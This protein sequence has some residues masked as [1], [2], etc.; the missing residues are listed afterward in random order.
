LRKDKDAAS[1]TS[2]P[3]RRR[4]AQV[5]A[6]RSQRSFWPGSFGA[7]ASVVAKLCRPRS[8]IVYSRGPT[9]HPPPVRSRLSLC[10]GPTGLVKDVPSGRCAVPTEALGWSPSPGRGVA[11]TSAPPGAPLIGSGSITEP[12]PFSSLGRPYAAGRQLPHNTPRRYY[13]TLRARSLWTG[14]QRRGMGVLGS[15]VGCRNVSDL[16]GVQPT[17]VMERQRYRARP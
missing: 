1:G 7:P 12:R 11:H 6:G 10:S 17:S 3:P 4:V 13:E 14:P 9:Y 16:P 5:G 8:V 15:S 2:E